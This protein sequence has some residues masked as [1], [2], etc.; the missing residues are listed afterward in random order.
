ML[1]MLG[2]STSV[3]ALFLDFGPV[4]FPNCSVNVRV[5][6]NLR[7]IFYRFKRNVYSN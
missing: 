2:E 7:S 6:G 5:E 1:G 4:S 3:G